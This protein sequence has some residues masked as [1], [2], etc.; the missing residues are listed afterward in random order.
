MSNNIVVSNFYHFI[1]LSNLDDYR[2]KL[3]DFC[4]AIALKGTVLIAKEGVN[5][6][7]AGTREQVDNF[8]NYIKE[9]FYINDLDYKENLTDTLPFAKTKVRIKKE[10]VAMGCPD[11]DVEKYK[12]FYID[13]VEWDQFISDPD[14]ILVD[15]RNNYEVLMG[16]FEGAVNP[17]THTF[18]EFPSWA[19]Q[20]LSKYKDKKIA[21]CCTGGIRCEKSTAYLATKG[22]KE[23]YHLKGG[24]LRY[25][26]QTKNQNGKWHGNCFV[27]DDRLAVD[28]SL[29]PVHDIKC[30]DCEKPIASVDLKIVPNKDVSQCLDC[31]NHA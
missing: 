9:I 14:V 24:I 11:L 1:I 27:F 15:T 29:A 10:T 26:E 22:F 7:I 4:N 20:Y 21:M 17:Q 28:K 25:L 31:Y 16:T 5:A 30:T 3:L 13:A 12:G 19:D 23:V 18:R 6:A 8:Y 2:T